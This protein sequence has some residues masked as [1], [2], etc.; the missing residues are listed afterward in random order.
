MF[1]I[2]IFHT[3]QRNK[4]Y[5]TSRDNDACIR[6]LNNH[7]CMHYLLVIH[8]LGNTQNTRIS[9]VNSASHIALAVISTSPY[10]T[11]DLCSLSPGYK[12]STG[13]VKAGDFITPRGHA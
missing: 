2:L 9:H 1:H 12:I 5:A 10:V 6:K 7:I 11:V 13:S 4:A 3:P 8:K